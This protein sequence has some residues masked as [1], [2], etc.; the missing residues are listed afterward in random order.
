MATAA[1]FAPGRCH[2]MKSCQGADFIFPKPASEL[3]C[4]HCLWGGRRWSWDPVYIHVRSSVKF[5]E[6]DKEYS[7]EKSKKYF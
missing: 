4:I 1:K 3:I 2:G 7:L 5:I 6:V